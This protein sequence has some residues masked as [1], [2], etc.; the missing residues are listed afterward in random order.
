MMNP[1]KIKRAFRFFKR[2]A[3]YGMGVNHGGP[4][5]TMSQEFLNRP[6]V[7]IPLEQMTGKAVAKCM[8]AG[9]LANP[10]SVYCLFYRLLDM[11]FMQMVP[12]VFPG[13][14]L[15]GQ[16]AGREKPLPDKLSGRVFIFSLQCVHQKNTGI[17][18]IQIPLMKVFQRLDMSPEFRENGLRKGHG[19]V[20]LSLAVMNR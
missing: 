11:R 16:L 9:T 18:P 14:V 8:G 2:D 3:F 5:I 20:F 17:S 1:S 19:P 10:G 12:P 15:P 6:N 4:H 13:R 7:I